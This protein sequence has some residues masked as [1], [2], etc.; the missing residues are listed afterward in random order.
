MKRFL[1]GAVFAVAVAVA[2]LPASVAADISPLETTQVILSC[3]DGHSVALWADPATLSSLTADVQA[4][5][6]GGAT[7]CALDTTA[8]DPPATSAKW[9]VYDYNPSGQ[10]IAPRN[11]PGSMPAATS[12]DTTTFDFLPGHYTALLTTTD[13]SLTG[14]QSSTTLSDTIQ[15]SGTPGTTFET[16]HGGGDCVNN[17]PA[18]VRFYFVS[19]AAS[20]ATPPP[21]GQ[22]PAGF[23]TRFWW[24][25]PV[26]LHDLVS[27]GQSL[28]ITADMTNPAEW[29]DW[30]GQSGANPTVTPAFLTA[31]SHVQEIGLSFGGECFF[32]TGVKANYTDSPPP[33]EMFASTFGES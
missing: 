17:V 33:Y 7:S 29:S 20:G 31:I 2:L 3:G 14:D 16:Q 24:S 8:A 27:D 25:H 10:E 19:P 6:A 21:P 18:A 26:Q 4:I 11:S 13:K 28:T 12:G 32:E 15:L 22:H 1:F 5:N 30:N 9:T 23:Y